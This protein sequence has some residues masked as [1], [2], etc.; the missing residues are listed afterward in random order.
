[1]DMFQ[2]CLATATFLCS[3]VAGF[4]FA[5]AIVIMPGIKELS[6]R[7]FIRAFQVTDWVIQKNHPVFISVWLGSAI[8][9]VI[10]AIL[11]IEQLDGDDFILM[12]IATVAYIAGVQLLTIIV[13]LPL[14][15][16]LQT[17]N[18]DKMNETEIKQARNNFESRWN[19]SNRLRTIISSCVSVLL[20]IVLIRH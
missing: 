19:V 17:F 9:L 11:S 13:H 1:M 18:V 2:I 16:R 10:S 7:E 12:T 14:N 4:L 20:I 3:L 5:Y 15:N 8:T 6:D